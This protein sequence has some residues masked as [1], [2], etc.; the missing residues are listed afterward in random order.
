MRCDVGEVTESLENEL[1]SSTT[2]SPTL[3]SLYLR[4]SSF[5]NPS[6]AS[7]TSQ[8]ILQHFFRFSY[9]TGSSLTSPGESSM[10]FAFS[11]EESQHKI[12]IIS[13]HSPT[14]PS[15]HLRHNSFS[16][17]SITLPSHSSFYNPSIALPTSQFILQPFFRFSCVTSSS[18]TSPELILQPSRHFTYISTY[19]PTFPSLHLRHNSFSSPS[20]ALPTS[21]LIL[22]PF[23]CFT[24]V[25][26]HSPTLPSPHLCH[27]SFYN[28]SGTSSMS[29]GE[30]PMVYGFKT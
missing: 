4:H 27:S 18:L 1:C 7:P 2:H 29:P 14:F 3:P 13:V 30:P 12:C 26:V 5:S 19:S 9:V 15:L 20:A 23:N 24:Y 22:Q 8:L 25:T 17:P 28:P 11:S 16:N 21:Q 6:V 10:K